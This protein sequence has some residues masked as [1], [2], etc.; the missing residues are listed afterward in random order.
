MRHFTK[1]ADDTIFADGNEF[2]YY[3]LR[4]EYL[5]TS[6]IVQRMGIKFTNTKKISESNRQAIYEVTKWPERKATAT[7]G[8]LNVDMKTYGFSE[9][10]VRIVATKKGAFPDFKN[11]VSLNEGKL[12]HTSS[13]TQS[14]KI[15]LKYQELADLLGED[16]IGYT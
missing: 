3:I 9:R 6:G 8:N 12:I 15:I 7:A 5:R 1:S 11:A 2:Y 13:T 4:R 10:D 16:W 14:K